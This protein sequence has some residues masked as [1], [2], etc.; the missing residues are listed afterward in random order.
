[1][2]EEQALFWWV[3]SLGE[4]NGFGHLGPQR[5]RHLL[6]FR[7]AE[8]SLVQQTPFHSLK[9]TAFFPFQEFLFRSVTDVI[10]VVGAAVFP[11]PIS[12]ELQKG[13]AAA[14]SRLSDG[15]SGQFMDLDHI[16]TVALLSLDAMSFRGLTHFPA[17]RLPDF[18]G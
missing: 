12:L 18:H 13:G 11:P 4:L 16:V 15:P 17:R 7:S 5:V 14:L 3:A 10:V 8:N 1:M 2:F 9:G 6:H